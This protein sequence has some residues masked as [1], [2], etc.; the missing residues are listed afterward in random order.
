MQI[1]AFASLGAL[2]PEACAL[3][4]QEAFSTLQ[5]YA[6]VAQAAVPQGAQPCFQV[7]RRGQTV[8]AVCPMWRVRSGYTAMT[9]PYTTQWSPLLRPGVDTA[10]IAAIGQALGR[11]WRH[12]ATTR[13][14]AFDPEASWLDPMIRG[15]RRAGLVPLQFSHF[16]NWHLRVAGLAWARYLAARPGALRSA[17]AR[18]SKRLLPRAA[19]TLVRGADGLE[20]GLA[21]YMRVYDASWKAPE[22]F[23]QFNPT[24][25][26]AAAASGSLRLGLL[27]VGHVPIAAQFWLLHGRPEARWAGVQKLAHDTAHHASAPGTVLTALMVRHL[28]DDEAVAELDFG[29]GDDPYKQ[30]WTGERRQRA[31]VML[32]APW[33]PAGAAQVVRHWAGRLRRSRT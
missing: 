8:L 24:L 30:Q 20:S 3:F 27:H 4:G 12:A 14:D 18:R 29:R 23:P 31:G 7:A 26:R 32:A 11:V 25:M 13:L 16:G 15:V 9:T 2:S 1:E 10:D 22:P 19:F 28:L 21:D 17:V 5:W 33:H 6:S